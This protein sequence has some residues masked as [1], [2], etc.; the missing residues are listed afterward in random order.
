MQ[1]FLKFLMLPFF[2]FFSPAEEEVEIKCLLEIIDYRGE[3][4]YLVISVLDEEEK[5]L[6]TIYVLGDDKS[7]FSELKS[8]WTHLRE[9]NLFSDQDFYP[10]ID[11]ISGPTISGGERRLFQIKVAKKLINSGKYLRFESAVE[12]KTYHL[13]DINI[14]LNTESLEQTYMG[15]GFIKKV[16]FLS[17]E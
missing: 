15:Q 1:S 11:G 8:F 17:A 13:N 9:N 2:L 3:G 6:K 12:D 7:W 5:Y 16:Q 4:A 10:L 14:A